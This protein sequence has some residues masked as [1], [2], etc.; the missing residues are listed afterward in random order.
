MNS[1]AK[2]LRKVFK[3]TLYMN[4]IIAIL[5]ILA[6]FFFSY[7]GIITPILIKVSHIHGVIGSVSNFILNMSSRVQIIGAFYFFSHGIV[8]LLL[9]WGL[10]TVRLWA[11]PIS[12]IFLGGFSLY[13]L[14]EI[15]FVEFSGIITF[16]M[17]FNSIVT[18]LIIDEYKRIK[19]VLKEKSA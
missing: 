2:K 12:I 13:Q 5:D 14:Y 1:D 18:L 7:T 19:K 16:F 11:Y 15:I 8:K 4:G 10:L 17:I 3:I 6:G 9:V